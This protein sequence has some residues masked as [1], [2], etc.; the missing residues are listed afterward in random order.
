VRKTAEGSLA[1]PCGPESAKAP[2][3]ESEGSLANPCGTQ[4]EPAKPSAS[5]SA[6]RAVMIPLAMD[7]RQEPGDS[8]AN[9]REAHVRSG[10]AETEEPHPVHRPVQSPPE[11]VVTWPHL[12][13][14]PQRREPSR[15]RPCD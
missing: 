3:P 6:S 10:L 14:R 12:R 15:P 5:E 4:A 13:G 1:N 2:P 7:S 11:R 9:F 8:L